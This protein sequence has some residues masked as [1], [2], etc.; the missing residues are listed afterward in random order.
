MIRDHEQSSAM[1]DKIQD[2]RFLRR[3]KKDIRLV[4]DKHIM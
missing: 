3:R 2:G 4:D 1:T